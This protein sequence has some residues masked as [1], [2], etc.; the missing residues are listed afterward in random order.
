MDYTKILT[1][2]FEVVWKHHALWLFGILLA[3]FGGGGGELRIPSIPTT[4][5]GS[6]NVVPTLPRFDF[7]SLVPILIAI[8]CGIILLV[9]VAI[10]LQFVSRGALIGL[11]HE[12]E[13]NQTA[14]TIKRGFHIGFG[15]FWSLLGVAIIVN[16]PL[17]LFT[18]LLLG[19]AAL[20]F[21]TALLSRPSIRFDEIIALGGMSSLL[22]FI[23]IVLFLVAVGLVIHPFYEFI[24]RA[25]VIEN[26]GAMDSVRQGFRRVRSNLASV[27]VLYILAIAVGAS[28]AIVMIPITLV[29]FAIL[30]GAGVAVYLM[31]NSITTAIIGAA[32]IGVPI[33]LIML[34]I[35]GLYQAFAS[36]FW[37]EAYLAVEK[38]Q[39]SPLQGEG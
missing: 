19:V 4:G 35:G 27:L 29:M 18:L 7:D 9:I 8:S 34:F 33:F 36:T 30:I 17:V 24:L 14:P 5:S 10:V 21:I 28:F 37:T 3:L 13:R 26:R 11:V 2:S 23:C 16:L 15:R 32:I 39:S 12:F 6:N 25:S 31:A 1:R 20:P 38:K 22:L